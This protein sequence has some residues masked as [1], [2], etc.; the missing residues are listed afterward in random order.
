MAFITL[1][2]NTKKSISY[3]TL[4]RFML[5]VFNNEPKYFDKITEICRNLDEKV[6]GTIEVTEF[7][8]LCKIIQSKR[9]LYPPRFKVWKRLNYFQDYLN[10]RLKIKEIIL[11]SKFQLFSAIFVLL[12]FINCILTMYV[13]SNVFDIIDDV[14]IILIVIEIGFRLIGLGPELFF[15]SFLNIVD[16]VVVVIGVFLELAPA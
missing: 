11:S 8:Q 13:E 5:Q 1:G 7:M 2:G 9:Y 4:V 3:D 10:N 16:L 6:D 12:S 14:I 15:N